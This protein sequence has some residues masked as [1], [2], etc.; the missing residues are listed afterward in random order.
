MMGHTPTVVGLCDM[1]VWN[2]S[3]PKKCIGVNNDGTL[4]PGICGT[5]SNCWTSGV[6]F[7]GV[8]NA[9]KIRPLYSTF[10][11]VCFKTALVSSSNLLHHA[12]SHDQQGC[13]STYG[14]NQELQRI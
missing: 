5:D 4:Y 12:R 9:G 1:T 7:E 10:R 13:F 8:I 2:A 14:R 6:N 11:V 3:N